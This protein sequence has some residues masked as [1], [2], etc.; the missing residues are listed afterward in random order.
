[1]N[2]GGTKSGTLVPC[3]AP[4]GAYFSFCAYFPTTAVVGYDVP[5][6]RT[7]D[8]GNPVYFHLILARKFDTLPALCSK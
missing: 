8:V 2:S 6:L 5:S 4:A 3:V 7:F 1:M